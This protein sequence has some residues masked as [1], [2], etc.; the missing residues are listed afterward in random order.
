[1]AL[2]GAGT[3]PAAR[4]DLL[5]RGAPA[6]RRPAQRR[7]AA[8]P[9]P[10]A[11]AAS[12]C[13]ELVE[14]LGAG[15]VVREAAR[16]GSAWSS[17]WTLSTDSGGE[18]FAKTARGPDAAA[19]F[20]AEAAG[21]RALDAPGALRVPRVLHAGALPGG[22]PGGCIVMERL[23]LGGRVDQAALG[24]RLAALHLAPPADARAAAGAFGFEVDN[25]IGGTPQL[26]GWS[27]DWVEFFRERR[28]RHQLRLARDARLDAL[29]APVLAGM[30]ALFEGVEVRPATLHGD[31]WS[32]NYAA[33]GGEPTV[34]DPAAYY[35]HAEAEFGRVQLRPWSASRSRKRLEANQPTNQPTKKPT[36]QPT[37]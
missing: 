29:A 25:A 28:L 4:R 1:M 2:P 35:G 32:G 23:N 17:A 5:P 13:A 18:F 14:E 34:V 3:K 16:G 20:A 12:G 8:P 22:A 9:P 11:A 31:L 27:D 10:R 21:L 24:A 26:N 30:G 37:H 36:N 6:A 33:C 7:P 19:V 15:R